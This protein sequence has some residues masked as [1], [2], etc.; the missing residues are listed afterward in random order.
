MGTKTITAKGKQLKTLAK[1]ADASLE[2]G[3]N[4]VINFGRDPKPDRVMDST[5]GWCW[6]R[7]RFRSLNCRRPDSVAANNGVQVRW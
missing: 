5:V 1:K 6:D 3:K 4:V 7:S 2:Q